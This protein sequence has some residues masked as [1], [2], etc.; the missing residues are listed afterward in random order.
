MSDAIKTK[1]K[2]ETITTT[3]TRTYEV[4]CSLQWLLDHPKML[5]DRPGAEVSVQ[6]PG[7]GDWSNM[8]VE[9]KQL[10]VTIRH[11]THEIE[12]TSQ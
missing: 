8:T 12:E 1:F 10:S 3:I 4:T 11:Q 9:P 5:V 2:S 6:I 7:G